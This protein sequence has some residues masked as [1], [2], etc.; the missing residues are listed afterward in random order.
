M[1]HMP[2]I[3]SS[4][5]VYTIRKEGICPHHAFSGETMNE[6]KET[7]TAIGG[8]VRA[9][10]FSTTLTVIKMKQAL[11]RMTAINHIEWLLILATILNQ[12]R[13]Q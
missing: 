12:Y 7:I 3:K 13:T 9:D 5:I 2:S 6:K 10:F 1:E 8:A 11:A 4:E